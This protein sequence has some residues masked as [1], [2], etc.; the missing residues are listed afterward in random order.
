[1]ELKDKLIK[2]LFS[3]VSNLASGEDNSYDA[4]YAA[5]TVE[6]CKGLLEIII[7]EDTEKTE[8]AA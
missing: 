7:P 4:G 6:T 1:M 5:G 8:S 2:H 3:K